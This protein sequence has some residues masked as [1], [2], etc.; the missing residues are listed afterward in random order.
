MKTA[1]RSLAQGEADSVLRG[2]L[3][4]TRVDIRGSGTCMAIARRPVA[5]FNFSNAWMRRT[6]LAA[7]P[8]MFEVRFIDDPRDPAELDRLLP[9]ADFLVTIA[10]PADWGAR[11]KRCQLVQLQGVGSDAVDLRA[12]REARVPL[13]ITPEGTTVGVAEHTIML[14]LALNKRLAEVHDSVVGGGFD[15]L[16]WREMCHTFSGS[17]LGLIGFGR[18]GQRVA[19]LARAFGARVIYHDI[20]RMPFDV[21]SE[22]DTEYR[23]FDQLLAEADVVSVHTPLNRDTELLFGA[24]E[25]GLMKPGSLF[26][27]TSRGGT[28]DM[29][30]LA[31]AIRSG[32]V[33]GAGLDVFNPQP[34][35]AD[36]PL[37]KLKSVLCTP[38]MAA[39]TVES[40]TEK[41]RS[42]FAN[43][44][45]VIR[46]EKPVNLLF[47]GDW[48]IRADRASV[49]SASRETVPMN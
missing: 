1:L 34:P 16:R 19:L 10:L 3:E 43:F 39:G 42:Q 35:P 18:I 33:R 15:S 46:G 49:M 13:A 23:P 29:D 27:N 21:D 6:I 45:R 41:A 9:G 24:R 30:A 7:A 28:Y 36:H 37:L 48:A 44:E 11:L 31:D 8:S 47:E 26:I 17:T 32:Q 38:H 40:H 14:I 20:E 25:F 5:V 2:R 22:F 4:A 12:L